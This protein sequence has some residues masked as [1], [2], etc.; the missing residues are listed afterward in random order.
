MNSRALACAVA[1]ALATPWS[2][3]AEPIQIKPGA[4][5]L[6]GNLEYF[7][8]DANPPAPRRNSSASSSIPPAAPV[9]A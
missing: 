8:Y 6:N 7:N 3:G 5:R 2:A 1:F 9:K 4:L